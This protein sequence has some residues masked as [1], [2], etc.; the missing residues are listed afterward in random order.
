MVIRDIKTIKKEFNIKIVTRIQV[1]L[2]EA[3]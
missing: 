2:K 3:I 1:C